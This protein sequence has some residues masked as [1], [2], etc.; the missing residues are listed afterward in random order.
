MNGASSLVAAVVLG[1]GIDQEPTI[2]DVIA[3]TTA[4]SAPALDV[5]QDV[6]SRSRWAHALPQQLIV[7]VRGDDSTQ[8]DDGLM[9]DGWS[10]RFRDTER[11]GWQ[12]QAGWDLSKL[13]FDPQAA[14]L[15]E[16][17]SDSLRRHADRVEKVTR[18][19][20]QRRRLQLQFLQRGARDEAHRGMVWVDIAELT[21]RIDA[22]CD[23]CMSRTPLA[24]WGP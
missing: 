22:L 8:F 23:G 17:E 10:K 14:R 1:A 13:A 15:V 2:R 16:L 6:V 3:A 20:F 4:A 24:W 21:A 7:R 18:L 9:D 12:V 19:Y 11:F 5:I